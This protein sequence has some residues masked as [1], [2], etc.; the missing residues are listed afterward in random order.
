MRVRLTPRNANS[1]RQR[2]SHPGDRSP[3]PAKPPDV[4]HAA[5]SAGPASGAAP[6]AASQTKRVALS[7]ASST[8]SRRMRHPYS[9]AADRGPRA[10][11]GASVEATSR[12]ASAVDVV[13]RTAAFGTEPL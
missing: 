11:H 7:G 1:L 9:A 12:T 5:P 2:T 4:F 8:A 10:A 3:A 6:A 13:A